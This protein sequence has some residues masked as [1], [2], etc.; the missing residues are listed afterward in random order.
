MEDLSPREAI[1]WQREHRS[2]LIFRPL[3]GSVTLVGGADLSYE[4]GS[5]LAYA[6]IVVLD[7]PALE[8]SA[9]SVV[10]VKMSFPY[11]PGLLSF[12]EIP[13]LLTAWQQLPLRP[14]LVMLD[15]HGYAHPRRMGV[16]C[17]FGL[18]ADIPTIGCAKR[19]LCG[20]HEP[21]DQKKGRF[22]PIIHEEEV[23]GYALRTKDGVKPVYVSPGH[24]IEAGQSRELAL[25][26]GSGYRLPETTRQ[27]HLLVNAAR[28]GEVEPGVWLRSD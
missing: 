23:V 27:A 6:G 17:H 26:C 8:I 3:S 1:R 24:L 2:R 18:V 14:Q 28:R 19:I 15:G 12:R 10:A 13:P 9:W 16:A 21:L 25:A 11:I 7:F 22:Q 20:R 4:I 5:D